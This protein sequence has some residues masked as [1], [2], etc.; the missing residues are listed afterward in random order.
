MAQSERNS[1]AKNR[2]GKNLIDN[3]VLKLYRKPSKQL[4]V[5]PNRRPLSNPNLTTYMKTYI[6]GG[7]KKFAEKCHHIPIL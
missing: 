6:R 5:F 2:A 3:K 7:F 1:H 4:H